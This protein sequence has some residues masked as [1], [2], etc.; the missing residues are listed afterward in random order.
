MTL[1]RTVTSMRALELVGT[2]TLRLVTRPVPRPEAGEELLRVTAVGICGSDLHWLED[3]G[4]GDARLTHPLVLGH[5]FAAVAESGPFKGRRVAVDPAISCGTCEF[6]LLGHPN[7]CS[8]MH[9]AGHDRDDG[10]LRE[11]MTWPSRFL[12]PM[13]D[14]LS[15]ADGAMLEPLGV[16]LH[17]VDLAH[18]RTGMSVGVFGCGPIGLLIVQ[19]A[20]LSGAARIVA[21]DLL[22]HRLDAARDCGA[23]DVLPARDGEE[24]KEVLALTEGGL[25]VVF[26]VA[27]EGPAVEA[28]MEAAKPGARVILVGIPSDDR[29]SFSAS[30]SR[31][32]GL[33]VKLVRRMKHTYERATML[34]ER[35]LVDVRSLVTHRFPLDRFEE[36]FQVASRREGIKVVI[37]PDA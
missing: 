28:S 2:G 34:V 29:I 18:L 8:R 9:F 7:F 26:E 14:T 12:F 15:P 27:G 20:R 13:P 22:S 31:R 35:G 17:S 37:E 10:A 24:A 33:T 32:K 5:E 30:V 16:A 36:A 3:A 25:D 1:E 11:W 21:T 6:C 23:T 19:L 4:I